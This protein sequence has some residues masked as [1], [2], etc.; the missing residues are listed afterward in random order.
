LTPCEGVPREG[1]FSTAN[2]WGFRPVLGGPA[3]RGSG[4]GVILGG[5]FGGYIW[6]CACDV[7][8]AGDARTPDIGVSGD[9]IPRYPVRMWGVLHT[10]YPG[11]GGM[12]YPRETPQIPP[13]G[14]APFGT[15]YLEGHPIYAVGKWPNR[16]PKWALFWGLFGGAR[17]GYRGVGVFGGTLY[18][19]VSGVMLHTHTGYRRVCIPDIGVC[20]THR[21]GIGYPRIPRYRGTLEKGSF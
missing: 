8:C 17:G 11:W 5:Y 13:R 10:W 19:R 2:I 21:G 9:A 16:G 3:K 4:W 14:R 7:G 15:L 6:G 12:G 18:R 20:I 1:P